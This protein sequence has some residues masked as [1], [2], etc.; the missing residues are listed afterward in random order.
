VGNFT[1]QDFGV[2]FGVSLCIFFFGLILFNR[3]EKSVA[4]TI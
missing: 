3:V 1:L 2:S 4:D